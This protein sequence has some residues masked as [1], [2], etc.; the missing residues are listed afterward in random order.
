[1]IVIG[2]ERLLLLKEKS[3]S[4]EIRHLWA[5]KTSNEG[6]KRLLLARRPCVQRQ[7]AK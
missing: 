3:K 5:T 1:M 4:T 2:K 7:Y 6:D